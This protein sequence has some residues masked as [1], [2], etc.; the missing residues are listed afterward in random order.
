M[1]RLGLAAVLLDPADARGDDPEVVLDRPDRLVARPAPPG[2]RQ[3]DLREPPDLRLGGGVL[4][5]GAD[6]V[7]LG[8]R[9]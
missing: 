3:V 4:V 2:L 6:E 5:L 7:E 8:V 1:A 9:A